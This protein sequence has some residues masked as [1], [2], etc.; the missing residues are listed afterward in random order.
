MAS[1]ATMLRDV[2]KRGGTTATASAR[3]GK[4]MTD[5]VTRVGGIYRRGGV[6][7][8]SV[9]ATTRRLQMGNRPDTRPE[10]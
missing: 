4:I 2:L 9:R 8:P 5:V 10:E 7:M 6:A 3:S 1:V